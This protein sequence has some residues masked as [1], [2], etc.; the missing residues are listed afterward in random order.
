[1]TVITPLEQAELVGRLALAAG[2]AGVIGW[3]RQLGQQP[4]GLRT[5]M[6]VSIGS[7]AFTMAG[8]Y[9]VSGL[10]TQ[11]DAGRIA[12]Q[13]VTGIGFI[14][15][16]T[17]WRSTGN[18]RVIRGLTTAASIWVAASIGMLSGYG[19]YV[20]A[21]GSAVVSFVVLRLLRGLERV[22]G[23]VWEGV[24][25]RRRRA[26]R[27]VAADAADTASRTSTVPGASSLTTGDAPDDHVPDG[28]SA[29]EGTTAP[30]A[31]H[32]G[33]PAKSSRKQRSK[34]SRKRRR[35]QTDDVISD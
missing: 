3:E 8:T 18:D 32:A 7:A 26:A 34:K 2:L 30:A 28:T 15:A 29:D 6:L 9:G 11:Q 16:G 13:I 10:G 19:L 25:M 35:P 4:A 17:I 27:S 31:L 12:A 22:P 5:H 24:L 14:G 33:N 23:L 21:A 20:L 1:V